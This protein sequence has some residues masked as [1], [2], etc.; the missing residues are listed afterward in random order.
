ML[1]PADVFCSAVVEFAERRGVWESEKEATS[2]CV[3]VE[4]EL[5]MTRATRCVNTIFTHSSSCTSYLNR[6]RRTSC[7]Y[8]VVALSRSQRPTFRLPFFVIYLKYAEGEEFLHLLKV[9][10]GGVLHL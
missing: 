5:G 7:G 4:N 8:V 1:S 3:P 2:A 9:G 10:C 6:I